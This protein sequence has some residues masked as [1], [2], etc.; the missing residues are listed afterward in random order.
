MAAAPA[1]KPA[2]GAMRATLTGSSHVPPVDGAGAGALDAVLDPDSGQLNWRMAWLG[3]SGAV[4]AMHFHGPAMPGDNAPVAV[5]VGE[6]LASP[7]QGSI[8][9]TPVQQAQ[10]RAGHWYVDL[11]TTAHPG[12]EI[13]GQLIAAP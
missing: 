5:P 3:M 6:A 10:V 12:G 11:H 2:P 4:T 1:P 13:R 9:L 7:L 8:A